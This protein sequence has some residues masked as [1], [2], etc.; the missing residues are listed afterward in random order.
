MFL[1]TTVVISSYTTNLVVPLLSTHRYTVVV[2]LLRG[3]LHLQNPLSAETL[4]V[5]M[6]VMMQVIPPP[7]ATPLSAIPVGTSQYHSNRIA[8]SPPRSLYFRSLCLTFIYVL[9]HIKLARTKLSGDLWF[10][11]MQE[12]A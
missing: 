6:M 9:L 12:R 3:I 5:M 8:I 11:H 10:M 4:V 1:F 2:C 7:P